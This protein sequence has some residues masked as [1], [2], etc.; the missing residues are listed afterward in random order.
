MDWVTHTESSSKKGLLSCL[1][2]S[3][4]IYTVELR[5]PPSRL[6]SSDAMTNWIDLNQSIRTLARADNFIFSFASQFF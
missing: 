4:S 3:E 1:I 2:S 5:P 6:S